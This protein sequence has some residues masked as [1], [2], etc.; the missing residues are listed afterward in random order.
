MAMM[1][2]WRTIKP[3]LSIFAL[4]TS[5]PSMHAQFLQQGPKLF[6]VEF[7]RPAAQGISVALSADGN[8]ALMG[9][10]VARLWVRANS[11]W[12][13]QA[14]LAA[15]AYSVALSA[16]A[17]TALMGVTASGNQ[18]GAAWVWTRNNGVWSA[19]PK[20]IGAGAG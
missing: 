16:D 20:L 1:F 4:A 13:L 3:L 5:L 14:R 9:G 19:G 7:S 8:T 12:N 17:N 15:G 6:E 18:P 2:N 11:V 10:D